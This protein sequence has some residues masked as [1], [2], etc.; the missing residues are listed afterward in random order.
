LCA[1][2]LQ[3][4]PATVD[5]LESA[6]SDE[7]KDVTINAEPIGDGHQK[8]TLEGPAGTLKALETPLA[9][10]YAENLLLQSDMRESLAAME[11]WER[12]F[13]ESSDPEDN[14]IGASLFRDAVIQFVGCFDKTAQFPL[15]AQDIYGRDPDGLP[16]F[17]WFKNTRDAYAAHKFGAQRQCVVGVVLKDGE[18]GIGH[19]FAKYRGQNKADGAVLRG[20][21]Q[22]AANHLDSR[23]QSLEKKLKEQIAGCLSRS[24]RRLRKRMSAR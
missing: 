2:W 23:V 20:F 6:M 18:R 21:M 7:Q 10:E 8:W 16:S 11:C 12:R 3:E 14:L 24:S 5:Y 13:A 1:R 19:L 4:K 15:S 22:T 9:K 17:Q